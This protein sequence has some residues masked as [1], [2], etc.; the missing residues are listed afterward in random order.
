MATAFVLIR[1]APGDEFRVFKKLNNVLE[2]DEIYPLFGEYDFLVKLVGDDFEEIGDIVVN[3][4]R[5]I[6][7]VTFTKTLSE[8]KFF[9]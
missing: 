1:I 5:I 6:R 9:H 2:I 4:I 8:A 7:G 3:K